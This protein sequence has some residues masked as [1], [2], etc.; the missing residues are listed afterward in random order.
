MICCYRSIICSLI[1]PLLL[2]GAP[3]RGHAQDLDQVLESGVLRHLGVP[4]A[5]FVTGSGDGLD[6]ELMQAFANHLGVHYRFIETTWAKALGDLTGRQVRRGNAA[7][8][9]PVLRQSKGDVIANGMTMLPW[10]EEVIA[11]S[12]PTFPSAVWLVA[13]ADSA[14]S[15]IVPSGSLQADIASVKGSLSGYSVLGLEDTCLDPA[16]YDLNE[17]NAEIRLPKGNL[18]LNE[19][20]PSILNGEAQTTLLDVPDA[21]IALDKWPRQLKIIGP[22]S[23]QQVMGVGFRKTSPKLRAAFNE[24]F[25][26]ISAD[27]TYSLMV[28]KYYPAVF[29]FYA[30]FFNS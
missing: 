8:E 27:G 15:P 6:V 23:S 3:Q 22:M 2:A 17:T 9:L 29:L 28:Q 16:L 13:R 14:L 1:L 4:Y 5:N 10:R 21:L 18:N 12:R 11:F 20:A 30:D 19:M 24:F 7:T 25:N 26:K